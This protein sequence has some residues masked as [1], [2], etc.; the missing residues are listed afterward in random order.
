[1]PR[2]AKR[3]EPATALAQFEDER[4]FVAL[5]GSLR[6]YGE[7]WKQQ[8][9]TVLTRDEFT[10]QICKR[11][12]DLDYDVIDTDHKIKRSDGGSDD[13]SNLRSVHRSCHNERHPEKQLK[14][15][16]T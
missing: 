8:Q 2:F 1:M 7:D 9:L 12:F 5:D 16:A 6:L 4:S 13:T 11:R 3:D 10:C 14:W 15:S